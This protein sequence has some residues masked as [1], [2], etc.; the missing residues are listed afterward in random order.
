M[1]SLRMLL[2]LL[3]ITLAIAPVSAAVE[4]DA[5]LKACRAETDDSRRLAC[6]DREIDRMVR[7]PE[8]AGVAPAEAPVAPPVLTAEERFG[9]KG[10]M[11]REETDRKVQES[12]ALGELQA[13]VTE[14]WTRSDGLMVVTLDNG[15][16]WKQIRPDSFFRLNSGDMVKIQPAA[17]NSFLMSGTSKRSTRVSRVK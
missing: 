6:Y 11:T 1:S 5:A 8:P 2:S 13:K 17:M 16:V 7:V 15:Q 14:I 10:S 9:R 12:R 3:V 4:A